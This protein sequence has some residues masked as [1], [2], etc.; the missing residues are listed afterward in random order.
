ME[1]IE[2]K[3]YDKALKAFVL[4]A[5]TGDLDAMTAVGIMY[6]SGWGVEQSD[7]LGLG[8]ISKAANQSHPKAQYSLGAI[9]YLGIGVPVDFDKA[10][11][12]LSLSANQGYLDAQHN[13]A[14]MYES[15]KGVD[16]T[17]RKPMSITLW[18]QES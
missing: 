7:E 4:A 16:K 3:D 5:K 2:A 9:Y 6:I 13:L 17:S 8:Y 11:S 14:E 12:W 15:G 10:F 1:L 18:L